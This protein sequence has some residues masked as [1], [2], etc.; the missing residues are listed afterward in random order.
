MKKLAN[1]EHSLLSIILL[2]D[3]IGVKP[4]IKCNWSGNSSSEKQLNR[5]FNISQTKVTFLAKILLNKCVINHTRPIQLTKFPRFMLTQ[6]TLNN[7][8]LYFLIFFS[9]QS[10]FFSLLPSINYNVFFGFFSI[11]NLF[12]TLQLNVFKKLTKIDDKIQVQHMISLWNI[13]FCKM[14][15]NEKSKFKFHKLEFWLHQDVKECNHICNLKNV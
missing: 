13:F 12:S 14:N 9:N 4:A 7:Y 2:P 1:F 10:H 15:D 8:F 3:N 6:M 5:E 11:Y